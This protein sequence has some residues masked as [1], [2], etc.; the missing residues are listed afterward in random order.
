MLRET[1]RAVSQWVLGSHRLCPP[2]GYKLL[3]QRQNSQHTSALWQ[4]VNITF[5]G[6][7]LHRT[8][9]LQRPSAQAWSDLPHTE[10]IRIPH[11]QKKESV[12]RKLLP[13]STLALFSFVLLFSFVVK[14]S[15]FF[16]TPR[17]KM[18][19]IVVYLHKNMKKNKYFPICVFRKL[20]WQLLLSLL[21]M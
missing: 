12:C 2:L 3:W 5:P 9:L 14:F 13:S 6:I 20:I 10:N 15:S 11:I 19:G 18:E 4:S 17:K 8:G 1:L 21:L 7:E 16:N